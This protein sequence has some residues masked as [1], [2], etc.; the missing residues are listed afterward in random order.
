MGSKK[1]IILIVI[2]I[3][4]LGVT[5]CFLFTDKDKSEFSKIIYVSTFGDDANPGTKALPK[6]TIQDAINNA[7]SL[8]KI[9]VAQGTYN[10]NSSINMKNGVSLI[11]GYSN[12]FSSK[13]PE[14]YATIINDVRNS[15]DI[16]AIDC[17][18]ITSSITIE[19]LNINIG[20]GDE[21]FGINATNSSN[22]IISNNIINGSDANL[23]CRGIN[24]NNSLNTI[25]INN[26]IY[27]GGNSVNFYG[28]N[29]IS[30]NSTIVN[31]LI[32][33]GSGSSNIGIRCQNSDAIIT[34][35]TIN[36]GSGSNSYCLYIITGSNPTIRNNIIFTTSPSGVG[37]FE[38]GNGNNPGS[39]RTNCIFDCLT[40]LYVD[41][42]TDF[43]TDFTTN[44]TTLEATN[45]LQ[46][47][48]N[49]DVDMINPSYYFVDWDGTDGNV[50]TMTDN[51]WHLRTT[52]PNGVKAG[53]L[54][55]SIGTDKDGVVRTYYWS[56]G[57]YEQDN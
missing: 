7:E 24:L 40:A 1:F 3:I 37:I 12:S 38:A 28:I 41:N 53:G 25:I 30:S 44:I 20:N 51:D 19:G 50:I 46:F 43:I 32:C 13:N 52:C 48:S 57:A 4:I 10:I 23:V 9:H 17:Q 56:I 5:N 6:L 14:L 11:G 45:T 42:G 26:T 2:F 8:D 15:G 36:G 49:R 54:T 18:N 33:G 16:F 35:N 55:L 29:D 31:N 21:S 27:C 22:M 47:F 34:N 39:V